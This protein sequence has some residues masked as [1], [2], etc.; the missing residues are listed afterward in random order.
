MWQSMTGYGQSS[1]DSPAGIV[2]C[3]IR[4]VNHRYLD[5]SLKAP[6]ELRVFEMD[7]RNLLRQHLKRGKVEIGL[8]LTSNGDTASLPAL[9]EDLLRSLAQTLDQVRE[10]SGERISVDP[11]RLLSWP[12]VLGSQRPDAAELKAPVTAAVEE[13][14]SQL[15]EF[16]RNE[17]ART[18]AVIEQNC[19]ALSQQ[20]HAVRDR[21]PIV[22]E[23]WL[24]RLRNRIQELA[25]DVDEQRLAQELAIHAQKMDVDEELT[26]LEGHITETQKLLKQ[27]K[28]VGQRMNFLLQE[29]NREANTLASK[30]QD[31]E[32]TAI[33]VEMKVLIEQMR[34]QIQNVE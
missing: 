32:I 16:R 8:R 19:L 30:S 17:G 20:V 15:Q 13:A 14:L 3:E 4:S 27:P 24:E 11:I 2:S 34:E 31:A 12:G 21:L 7:L 10:I 9:D 5:V 1:A 18:A 25:A 33:A 28:A 26:R 6:E 23:A 29:F 22:R